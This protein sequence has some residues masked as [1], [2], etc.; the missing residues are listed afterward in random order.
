MR[1][2]VWAWPKSSFGFFHWPWWENLNKL[3]GQ[4]NIS[5]RSSNIMQ[6]PWKGSKVLT[7][8]W[9]VESV[10]TRWGV[11]TR[12]ASEDKAVPR[13]A[14]GEDM[15]K[16]HGFSLVHEAQRGACPWRH[17]IGLQSDPGN[18]LQRGP[19][20][21]GPSCHGEKQPR[22]TGMEDTREQGSKQHISLHPS[23]AY[24]Q[25]LSAKASKNMTQKRVLLFTSWQ[26]HMKQ[27]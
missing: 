10:Y 26:L 11:G 1:E 13:R 25:G 6:S 14:M 24:L 20:H 2:L 4:P 22:R 21:W 5:S 18:A 3:F 7:N 12:S 19:E 8:C 9:C 16:R 27:E 23:K 15:R 17:G